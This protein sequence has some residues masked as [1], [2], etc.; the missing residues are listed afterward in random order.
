MY[1]SARTARRIMR[2][3][4]ISPVPTMKRE[5]RDAIGQTLQQHRGSGRDTYRKD[6]AGG[7]S[8]CVCVYVCMCVCVFSSLLHRHRICGRNCG[9]GTAGLLRPLRPSECEDATSPTL[10][11]LLLRTRA[12]AGRQC[13][14][15]NSA[16]LGGGEEGVGRGGYAA[17]PRPRN[18]AIGIGRVRASIYQG[19][20]AADRGART[21]DGS[22][23]IARRARDRACARPITRS[24]SRFRID[25]WTYSP[26]GTRAMRRRHPGES[27]RSFSRDRLSVLPPPLPPGPESPPSAR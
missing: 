25:K 5:R 17:R 19:K 24:M 18:R 14:S 27:L 20:R 12:A 7:C 16:R 4:G 3:L 8:V 22:V 9:S 23:Y 2:L 21:D 10:L 26:R 1:E 11:L 13:S 6:R 15:A